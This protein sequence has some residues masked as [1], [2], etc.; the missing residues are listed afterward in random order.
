MLISSGF[1]GF[2]EGIIVNNHAGLR[3]AKPLWISLFYYLEVF[4]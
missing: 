3:G 2:D 1:R 4:V